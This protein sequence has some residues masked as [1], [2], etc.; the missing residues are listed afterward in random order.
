[1]SPPL[2][3]S[4]VVLFLVAG[5]T[6]SAQQ[7]D[8]AR[9]PTRELWSRPT[10]GDTSAFF[11]RGLGYGT[12]AYTTPATVLL[13]K[14]LAIFQLRRHPRSLWTIPYRRGWRVGVA[15]VFT[16]PGAAVE[17]FGGWERMLRSELLP[18][19]IKFE[20]LNWVP[21]YAL[22]LFGGGFTMRHMD[23]WF[24]A[25]DVAYPR[26][27]AVLTTYGASVLNELVEHPDFHETTA[28]GVADLLFFDTA[29]MLLFHWDQPTRFFARTLQFM[30]WS[31]QAS[32]TLPNKQVQNNGQYQIIKIPVGFD[33]TRL[34]IRGGI[35]FQVG[36]TRKLDDEHFLTLAIGGDT[37]R[38]DVDASGHETIE[39]A[40]GGGVYYDRNNSLL[41]SVTSSPM[42]NVLTINVYPGVAPRV[43][44]EMGLWAVYT[45]HNEFRFGIV[46]SATLNVGLGY[47]R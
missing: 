15:G 47:G 24:R 32:L 8:T 6:G 4:A 31:N 1:M 9:S 7:T 23:E 29:A 20:D 3:R 43:P 14:G 40:L 27:M 30:D 22:H 12:D 2:V 11:Y 28:G 21:N 38:R 34:F 35:G 39:F 37:Q 19:T 33:R 5:A 42:E 10:A 41:W 18:G 45:R 44:K 36:A 16:H 25:H 46:H 13:N 17:R 26:L